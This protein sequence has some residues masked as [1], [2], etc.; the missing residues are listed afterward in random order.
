MIKDIKL[1][2]LGR[3]NTN[4]VDV[5]YNKTLVSKEN[6]NNKIEKK[7]TLYFSYQTIVGIEKDHQIYC[8][9]NDWSTTT[10]KLLNEIQRD[11]K[12][13]LEADEFNKVLSSV[14]DEVNQ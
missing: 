9:V 8:H 5:V 1:E 2:N 13:R 3:V 12:Q 4:K 10:G 7:I 6:P 14:F 11:K